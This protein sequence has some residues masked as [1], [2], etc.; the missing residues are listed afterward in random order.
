MS[1]NQV[2]R[3]RLSAHAQVSGQASSSRPSANQHGG[4]RLT[5]ASAG[6]G[7]QTRAQAA[8]VLVQVLEQG[9][10]LTSALA[11][12]RAEESTPGP[13]R[14][15]ARDLPLLHELCFGVLRCLPRLDA[16][17][18][19]LLQRPLKSRDQDLRCLL[20]VGLYQLD[21]LA[22]PEHAAVA[23]TVEASTL[24]DKAW[25]RG[26]LNA[27]LRRFLRERKALEARIQQDEAA[28]TWFPSW[29]LTRLQ[30]AWPEHWPELVAASNSRAPMFVRVNRLRTALDHYHNQL[31]AN[32]ISATPLVGCPD[33]LQL[34]TPVPTSRLPGFKQGLVSVQDASAQRAATLLEAAPGQRVLDACAAPGGKT[35]HL[36]E[37]ADNQLQLWALDHD[38]ERLHSLTTHLRRLGL[39]A[40]I[41]QADASTTQGDWAEQ[42]YQRILLDAPCSGTGVIR[43]HPDIKWLRREQDIGQLVRTQARLLDALWPLLEPQGTLLYV[44]CSLLPEENSRQIADFLARW[45]DAREDPLIGDAFDWGLA[46]D[47]GRQLLPTPEGGDG[48]FFARLIKQ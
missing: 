31:H 21:A 16:L 28:R 11:P 8:R 44:T 39:H 41:R 3:N 2:P 33:G 26:L 23:A 9:R 22:L 34:Q 24:L 40:S 17:G 5:P 30:A 47:H 13:G 25:A 37:L 6:P 45:P 42:P 38:H 27:T 15:A 35:A 14:L 36:Q 19:R 7:A 12:F 18:A 43:R 20:R 29:L 46:R 32:G 48:F 10:S 4:H 1:H